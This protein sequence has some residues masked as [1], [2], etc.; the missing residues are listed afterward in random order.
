GAFPANTSLSVNGNGIVDLNGNTITVSDLIDPQGNGII[1]NTSTT[2]ATVNYDGTNSSST[3]SEFKGAFQD[4]AAGG[5]L[6]GLTVS[7]GTLTI[8]NN[9]SVATTN[10]SG[11]TLVQK[12]ATLN[13][14]D[15]HA[16]SPNTA[17]T[18]GAGDT[19][20]A[21]DL[22]GIDT[23]VKSVTSGTTTG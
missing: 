21:F 12:D 6:V 17:I 23:T 7:G 9:A 20:G 11:P 1:S 5:K 22:N 15:T 18:L 3:T 4:G 14:N 10:Y 19:G 16:M 8:S 13:L 2:L